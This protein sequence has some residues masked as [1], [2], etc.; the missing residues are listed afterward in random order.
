MFVLSHSI[1][2]QVSFMQKACW[3]SLLSTANGFNLVCVPP[4]ANR[5]VANA[6][7]LSVFLWGSGAG[8]AV[9]PEAKE[10][11]CVVRNG[12]Y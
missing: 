11:R 12:D 8:A 4:P 2:P 3:I 1:P 6:F 10:E 5:T 9:P 7:L